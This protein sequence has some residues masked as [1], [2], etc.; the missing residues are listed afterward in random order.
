MPFRRALGSALFAMALS[1]LGALPALSQ[2]VSLT[3]PG[4]AVT[5]SFN[6]L[7][8]TAGS[9]TNNL[10]LTGWFMTE[11]GGGARD[12]DQYAV[13]TGGSNT[14]DTYSYGAAGNSERALGGLQSGTL[15]PVIGACFT[16]NTGGALSSLDVAYT[17]EQWRISN[18]AA[19]RDDRMDFQYSLN[20]TD[21][22]T[23][24]WTD[25]NALDFTNPIKTAGTAGAL[26]GNAAANRTAVSS[27]IASL[28][29]ANGATFWIR[30]ND[31]NASGADDSLAVDDFSLTPQGGGGPVVPNLSINDV[32]LGEGNAGTTSFTFTVS[33]SAPAGPGGVT[34]DVATANN[35][36]VA[37]GDYTTNSLTGQTIPAGSSTYSFTVLV[38]GDTAAE[39]NETFFVNVTNVT[40]ANVTDGQGTGTINNDDVSLTPIHD[41]QGPGNSSP[42]VG[43]TVTT[44]GIV[45][46]IKNNGFFLQEP[47]A[48]VDA[49]PATSE[50]VFVFTSSAPAGTILVGDQVQVTATV[51]EFVPAQDPL[52]PPLTELSSPTV[53]ELSAGNPLPTAVT[54]S[55]S[56]PDPAGPVDQLERLEGMRVQVASLTV[57]APTVGNV[58]EPNATATSTGVFFGVV[59]GV[60]RPFREPGIQA[61]DPAPSGGSIPPIPRWDANPELLRVDSDA[62][63][64]AILNVGTGAEVT[65]LV[66]PLDYGFRHYTVLPESTP[67]TAGGPTP[68]SVTAPTAR[69]FTIAAYNLERFFDTVNDPG[70]GE[71]VLTAAAYDKRLDKASLGIRNYLQTPDILGIIEIENLSTL[72]DL[73]DQINSDAGA[74]SPEYVAYLVEGNDVGGIDVGFLVKTAEVADGTPRVEVIEV[75]QELDGTVLVNPDSSTDIL[76][77]RPPLRLEAIV[78]HPGGGSYPVTVIVNHMRSLNNSADE[79]PGANGWP[80]AGARVRAKRQAQAEDLANLVQS[81]QTADPAQPI[82]LIGDFNAFEFNDGLGDSMGVIEG[83]PSP[84]NETAV[85]G[86]GADLVNPDL[87]NLADTAPAAERY[88]FLFDGN[89]Q[90]LDHVLVNQAL[91][92]ST[93]ARRVE[94]PRINADFPEID[95][96]A[97]GTT[98]L[99]DHDPIV[100]FFEV[101]EFATAGLTISKTDLTDPVVAGTTLGYTIEVV[102]GGPDDAATLEVTDPLPTGTT[103]VSLTASAGWSCT[104]PAVGATGTVTCTNALLANGGS[105]TFNLVVAID[106]AVA[107]GTVL[108]NT[109]TVTTTTSDDTSDNS[110]TATTTVG[111]TAD[112]SLTL[113]DAPDPVAAGGVLT[114]TAEAVNTGPSVLPNAQVTLSLPAGVTFESLVSPA[115]WVCPGLPAM[116]QPVSTVTCTNAAFI[117]SASFTLSVRVGAA[118][119]GG[120]VLTASGALT[121]GIPD[122]TGGDTTP[123]TTTTVSSAASLSATKTATGPFTPGATIT[124]TIV[125][126]NGGPATQGDNPGNEVTDILPAPLQLV[127]ASASSGTAVADTVNDTVTWNGSI[128]AGASV[129]ITI[130]AVIPPGTPS[131]TTISNQASL[132]FDADGDGTNEASGVSDN[133]AAAGGDNPTDF[134]VGEAVNIAEIPTLDQIGLMALATILAMLGAWRLRRR[135][136]L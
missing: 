35:T 106:A 104:T 94:H 114:Y 91:I 43:A 36:A 93:D 20:A 58:N 116:G 131:G 56:F 37:P 79:S 6:T 100:A 80:T 109:A 26:D 115:G 19:A 7:S 14:G 113:T 105:A 47:D 63:G 24:T 70:I 98:R 133:P 25:V 86:D 2:C 103:F 126:T 96:N 29:I 11:T 45:T 66:G 134:V 101:A 135:T 122:S 90:S 102:N 92:A 32:T 107:S 87:D 49:D 9:T 78:H 22:T 12:N 23:G 75:V 95:R 62:I 123:S 46:G 132:S 85:P 119:P 44:R 5:Q 55:A 88:S 69:E 1:V 81:L 15:V 17:G 41:I 89:A 34:F 53:T 97:A 8:S 71:P 51:I 52:Q 65:G 68:V 39:A 10:T 77:D 40:G 57:V 136:V 33:L 121:G 48:S 83:T 74:S 72:Q 112:Y 99:A 130:Q 38:N 120:T 76:N 60:A 125:V 4:S 28:S 111:V 13:D 82:V 108:S 124:Y 118:T 50:G 110:A 16:N 18:T 30:W 129:T 59:T 31:L 3:T 64:A 27:S 84:D 117:G 21:L 42:I 61:P 54:L 128:A 73:A 67:A 127:S